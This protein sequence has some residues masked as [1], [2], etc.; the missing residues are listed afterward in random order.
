MKYAD[1]QEIMLGDHVKLG[2]DECGIV[3]ASID[4]GE[5][6]AENPAAQWAY[7]TTGVVI[8]FPSFGLIHY[9]ESESD[10]KLI[11]PTKSPLCL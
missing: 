8:K 7:L 1:G 4:T 9:K 6:T 11:N 5:Y 3:V 10:L 2:A